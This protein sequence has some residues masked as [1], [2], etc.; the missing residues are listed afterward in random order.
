MRY[1]SDRKRDDST[2]RARLKDLANERRRYGSPRLKVLLRREGFT[3]NHKRIERIYSEE[4]L[5]VRRRKRK[6]TARG[7]QVKLV[8]TPTRPN[9][10][11]SMDFV[12]DTIAGG[13]KLRCLNIVDDF[14]RECPHIEADR[15]LGGERVCRVLDYLAWE[16]GLPEE[17]VVDNGPEFTSLA[18]DRWAHEN[19]V[20]LRFIDPGKPVQNCY[21]ESFNGKF[22]DECLNENWFVNLAD[23]KRKIEAYRVDYNTV[24]PHSSLGNLTPEEF[25]AKHREQGKLTRDV[26]Q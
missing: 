9:E 25:A 16:R 8:E 24:R 23:A 22:R 12:S 10:R 4:G 3:D 17:I 20:V 15:S 13:A 26:V 2:L 6:R 18:L 21:I 7:R 14:T 1:R 11:W 5:Q 19:G